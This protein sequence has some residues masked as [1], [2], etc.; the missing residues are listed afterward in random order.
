ML[1]AINGNSKLAISVMVIQSVCPNVLA[2]GSI[3]LWELVFR[4][5]HKEAH[6]QK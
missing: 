5:A 4:L 6:F 3:N 1:F 2:I